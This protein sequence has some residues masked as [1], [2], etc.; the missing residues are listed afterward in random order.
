M[1]VKE[2]LH[3]MNDFVMIC[4]VLGRVQLGEMMKFREL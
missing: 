2:F 4:Q 1:E 3:D